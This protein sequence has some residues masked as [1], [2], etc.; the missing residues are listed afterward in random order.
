MDFLKTLKQT[1]TFTCI[2]HSKIKVKFPPHL[3]EEIG[4]Y[5]YHMNPWFSEK[6]PLKS[7]SHAMYVHEISSIFIAYCNSEFY[8][9]ITLYLIFQ[10]QVNL[11][12][13]SVRLGSRKHHISY[14]PLMFYYI[15]NTSWVNVVAKSGNN[16]IC[17]VVDFI[18]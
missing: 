16:C 17:F 11:H 10:R 3:L 18:L 8:L 6:N 1:Q 9:D 13:K 7:F 14:H 5:Y 12:L 4:V 2:Y 15:M